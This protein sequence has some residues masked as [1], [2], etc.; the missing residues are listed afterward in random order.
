MSKMTGLELVAFARSKIKTPYVYGMKGEVMTKAKYD[1]LKKTYG[2]LVWDSDAKKIG[3]VCVDCSGLIS[4]A[5]GVMLGSTQWMNKANVKK[6][7]STISEAP[8]GA[9]VWMQGHIGIYVGKK[10]N[11]P[12]QIAADGS[13][14]G[15]REVPLSYNKFTHWLLVESVFTYNYSNSSQNE[16]SDEDMVKRYKTVKDV[17]DYGQELVQELIDEKSIADKNNINLTEDMVR[18]M[19]IME[20]HAEKKK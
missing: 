7:I 5:S 8:I 10:N 2:D 9:L 20:R 12:Y 15:V 11:V 13:A 14:Y 19:V 3:K 16:G 1:W 6:P 17:P 4:W 18:V